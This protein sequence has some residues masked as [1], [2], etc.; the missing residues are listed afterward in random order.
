MGMPFEL[1]AV[2]MAQ[3]F[4]T[5]ILMPFVVIKVLS[6]NI[7]HLMF[8]PQNGVVER[9]NRTLVEMARTM[10]DEH[11]TP[12]RFW[13]E[14]VNTACHVS[15]R[16]FLR[17]FKKKTCYELIHGRAP[18]VSHFRFFGCKCFILKKGKLDKF[19]ARSIDGI[20]FGYASHSRAYRVLNL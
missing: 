2:T 14:V 16:I 19:E 12:R 6:I 11:R 13:V 18:R 7:L 1:Y 3:N 15:N 20:C 10:L 5:I 9:K 17:A 4:E 8:P